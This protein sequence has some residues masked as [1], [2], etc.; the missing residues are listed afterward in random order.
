MHSALLPEMASDEIIRAIGVTFCVN[1]K[2]WTFEGRAR[3]QI[4]A[5]ILLT[6]SK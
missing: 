2:K 5:Y 6:R 3:A 1:V 4:L